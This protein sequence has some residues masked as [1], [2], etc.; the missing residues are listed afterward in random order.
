MDIEKE[1][2]LYIDDEPENFGIEL[3]GL[4][5]VVD[6]HAGQLNLDHGGVLF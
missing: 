5:L 2:I 3:A 6:Q 4:V 1:L